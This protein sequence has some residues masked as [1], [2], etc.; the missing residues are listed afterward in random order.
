MRGE[1]PLLRGRAWVAPDFDEADATIA[2]LMHGGDN[3]G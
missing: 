2:A 1:D 3:P